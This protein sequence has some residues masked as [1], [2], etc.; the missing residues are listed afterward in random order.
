M[1]S[2]PTFLIRSL[3]HKNNQFVAFFS[4]SEIFIVH[5]WVVTPYSGKFVASDYSLTS[6]G[7]KYYLEDG[8][9][10]FLQN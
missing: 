9:S 3:L 1:S 4:I 10:I 8:R 7:L 5:F 2:L 6:S